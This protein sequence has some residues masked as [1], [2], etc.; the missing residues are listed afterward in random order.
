MRA[1]VAF[2]LAAVL[3]V[4]A[5]GVWRTLPKDSETRSTVADALVRY[6]DVMDRASRPDHRQ[7]GVPPFGVYAY[8]TTGLATVDSSF[9]SSGHSYTGTSTIAITPSRCGVTARWQVLEERWTEEDLCIGPAATRTAAVREFFEFFEEHRTT[10]LS[11]ESGLAPPASKLKT[12]MRWTTRCGSENAVAVSSTVVEGAERM[13]VG[14][15]RVAAV[16]L[17][18]DISL[19]GVTRGTSRVDS[20]IRR[21]DGLLLRKTSSTE[22]YDESEDGDLRETFELE[23][24]STAPRR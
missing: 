21:R 9:A 24:V 10:S 14:D 4:T 2:F 11:C 16:H 20:W 23:L 13:A 6:R 22:G 8:R 1:A 19:R 5:F 18:A 3:G 12:G 7:A 17:H 15:R